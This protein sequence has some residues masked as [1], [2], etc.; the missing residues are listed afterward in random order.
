MIPEKSVCKQVHRI[1][2]A[3]IRRMNKVSKDF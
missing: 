1:E 2:Q 3:W